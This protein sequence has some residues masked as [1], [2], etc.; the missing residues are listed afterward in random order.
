MP[1]A[2]SHQLVRVADVPAHEGPVFCADE[3]ALYYTTTPRRRLDGT[4]VV[5]IE[6][7]RLDG[8][9]VRK[10]D[11]VVADANAANG[12]CMAND[13]GLLVCEQGGRHERARISYLDRRTGRRETVVDSVDGLP[14]SSPN[15]IVQAGDGTI[16]FTDPS[17][18]YWQHFRPRPHRQDAVVRVGADGSS[19]I[20][21]TD[22]DKPNGIALSLDERTLFVG[23][24]GANHEIGSYV[25]ERPHDVTAFD[26]ATDGTLVARRQF[27]D[28]DAGFPDG[29]KVGPDGNVYVSCADGVLVHSPDGALLSLISLPGAVNFCFGGDDLSTL[30]ITG[31]DAVWAVRVAGTGFPEGLTA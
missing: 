23:D 20:A 21:S 22:L 9:T 28:V 17:Y 6:R 3:Q 29:L 14:L 16:W 13:G 8:L 15:D 7:L 24:S 30:F 19:R 11:V 31:D 5:R 18:G 12:M 10:R 1:L 2:L 26:I 27:A 4:P 25:A